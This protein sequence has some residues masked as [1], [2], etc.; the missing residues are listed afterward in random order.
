MQ[1]VDS[2][3]LSAAISRP[4]LAPLGHLWPDHVLVDVVA[5]RRHRGHST[6]PT[7]GLSLELVHSG[8]LH[9]P[10]GLVPLDL[11]AEYNPRCDLV[12][13]S[14]T[15]GLEFANTKETENR[16]MLCLCCWIF[17]RPIPPRLTSSPAIGPSVFV[18][19]FTDYS[20][21]VSSGCIASVIR[22]YYFFKLN[23]FSDGNWASV[24]L[25]SWSC[26][27]PGVILISACMPALWPLLRRT[28]SVVASRYY[29][30]DASTGDN[31]PKQHRRV[32]AKPVTVP[33]SRD[34]DEFVLLHDLEADGGRSGHHTGIVGHG[35]VDMPS[36]NGRGINVKKEFTWN[37]AQ[38]GSTSPGAFG[39][40]R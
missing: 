24:E 36:S 22:M 23:A 38:Q 11:R 31:V 17:V 28:F 33:A 6:M 27:E 13:D 12:G 20:I 37:V 10:L 34:H 15:H 14:G 3:L 18:P 29:G 40:A 35:G 9:R 7:S 32:G 30:T 8:H 1:N 5:C 25:M 2:H 4:A 26:A 19:C 21:I 39:S 16:S